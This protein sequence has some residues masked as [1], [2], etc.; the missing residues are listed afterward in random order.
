MPDFNTFV[1]IAQTAPFIAVFYFLWKS[2]AI[3]IGNNKKN[4]N[5]YQCQIDS[6]SKHARIANDEVGKIQKDISEI[7]EDVAFI[8]GKLSA[9]DSV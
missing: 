6:L 4:G 5:S 8:R 9:K 3:K 7:K 1:D 2:G